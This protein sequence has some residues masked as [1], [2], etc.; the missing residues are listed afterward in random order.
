MVTGSAPAKYFVGIL[1]SKTNLQEHVIHNLS[2]FL[3][4]VDYISSWHNFDN[5]NYYAAEMG[6]GLK[7]CFVSFEK[8]LPPELIY[9]AKIWCNKVED[10]FRENGKRKINLDPGYIDYYKVVLASG[11]YG[12]HKIAITKGCWADFVLMYSKGKWEALPWCFPDL[13]TGTYDK[14]FIEIRRLFKMARQKIG[15]P[16]S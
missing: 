13:A 7:R 4:T 2:D 1:T 14:D 6:D 16:A 5:T 8:L 15:G 9:K 12:G 11:K 10:D 3:G